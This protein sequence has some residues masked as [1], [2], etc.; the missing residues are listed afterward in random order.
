M[1]PSCAC[2]VS[3]RLLRWCCLIISL[4]A[5]CTQ[6]AQVYP[7]KL[8]DIDGDGE[9][10]V[11]DLVEA[12]NHFIGTSRLANESAVFADI[13]QDGVVNENDINFIADVILKLRTP[14]QLPLARILE[15]SPANGAT[16]V[17][18]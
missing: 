8:G 7:E 16:E 14:P 4:A 12:I 11:L 9:I 6:A 1:K 18:V 17:S 13:N 3:C 15:T 10:T 2:V 5:L